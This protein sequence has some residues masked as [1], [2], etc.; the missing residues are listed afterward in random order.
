MSPTMSYTTVVLFE[1]TG[2]VTQCVLWF[3]SRDEVSGAESIFGD[4]E[5][6]GFQRLGGMWDVPDCVIAEVCILL[7]KRRLLEAREKLGIGEQH[8]IMLIKKQGRFVKIAY[9][10]LFIG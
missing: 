2:V 4:T 3:P 5:G 10:V 6:G 7:G 1:V 9:L 8:E